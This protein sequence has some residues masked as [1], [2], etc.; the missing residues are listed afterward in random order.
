MP[1]SSDGG[2]RRAMGRVADALGVLLS[3][4]ALAAFRRPVVATAA[5]VVAAVAAALPVRQ[6]TVVRDTPGDGPVQIGRA[7]ASSPSA[8]VIVLAGAGVALLFRRPLAVG[9][10]LAPLVVGLTLACGVA[11]ALAA[12]GLDNLATSAGVMLAAIGLGQGIHLVARHDEEK[13]RA[14]ADDEEV[15]RRTFGEAG[16]VSL[17][18]VLPAAAAFACLT[19]PDRHAF[20]A[21]GALSATGLLLVLSSYAV[22]LP[23][24]LGLHARYTLRRA[25]RTP[26][27]APRE[28]RRVLR[29]PQMA[30][31]APPPVP[32]ALRRPQSAACAPQ[33]APCAPQSAACAPQ[34]APCASQAA[35]WR[36]R[37][38][39]SLPGVG[40]LRRWAPALLWGLVALG[41]A[42]AAPLR[43]MSLPSGRALEAR[44]PA[45]LA[46]AL[47]AAFHG[48]PRCFALSGA[49]VLLSL[50]LVLGKPRLALLA[51]APAAVTL[52]VTAGLLRLL[53]LSLDRT[54]VAALPILF[55]VALD[56]GAHLVARVGA[57]EPLVDVWRH[58]GGAVGGA[59]LASALGLG[60]LAL[61]AHPRLAIL[62]EVALLGLVV[63]F[64]ACVLLLPAALAVL[65][66]AGGARR[67]RRASLARWVATV[68]GAGF[69]PGAPGTV[70]A[71]VAL[72][73]AWAVQGA[74]WAARAAVVA[75]LVAV[76]TLATHRYLHEEGVRA[77][78]PR[79]VVVDETVGCLVAV[80]FVPYELPWIG[81]AF[82]LFRALDIWKPGP[83]RVA[84]RRLPGALG[85][86]GDDVLAGALAGALLRGVSALAS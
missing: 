15:I 7:L 51:L 23:A 21:L 33:T 10:V 38:G 63:S 54:T 27:R 79:E 48:A 61:A 50:V 1:A 49:L 47:A 8:L 32:R 80:A 58:T 43:G 86:V 82:V 39:L 22:L 25:L 46:D 75:A 85:V 18:V 71:L 5:V 26:S 60:G 28:P 65:P 6:L 77:K 31:C 57:G 56:H 81:A 72:P 67:A 35:P 40:L 11:G 13:R 74:G 12:R 41:F 19:W 84:E 37:A 14:G 78:D 53:G 68:G 44:E 34:T 30:P 83:V 9:L 52:P 24:L 73:I 64:V 45:T 66:L 76:A 36:G 62:S 17:A 42:A 2:S 55:G 29:R 16:R 59:I 69:S 3:R 70:G 20:R 4:I